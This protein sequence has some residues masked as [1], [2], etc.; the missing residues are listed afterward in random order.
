MPTRATHALVALAAARPHAAVP[1]AAQ[2]EGT[3]PTPPTHATH[4]HVTQGAK[5]RFVAGIRAFYG[6]PATNNTNVYFF[7]DAADNI[8][9]FKD[10]PAP[11]NAFVAAQISC[12]RPRGPDGGCAAPGERLP[13]NGTADGVPMPAAAPT[14]DLHAGGSRDVCIYFAGAVPSLA[15]GLCGATPAEV[16]E[17]RG[18]ACSLCG[19]GAGRRAAC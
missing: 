11:G 3:P 19:D 7:D 17:D 8:V 18:R 10:F 4:Q 9:P 6:M 12:G 2:S 13:C 16:E 1:G 14:C 15:L 5:H